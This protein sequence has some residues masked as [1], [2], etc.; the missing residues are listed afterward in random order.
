MGDI[1]REPATVGLTSPDAGAATVVPIVT[2]EKELSQLSC[3][4]APR[5]A[6]QRLPRCRLPKLPK[7]RSAFLA[8]C[9][10]HIF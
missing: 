10:A 3:A 4:P 9:E 1:G 5:R 2:S 8:T 7:R 6:A